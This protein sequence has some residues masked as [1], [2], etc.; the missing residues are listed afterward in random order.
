MVELQRKPFRE[1]LEAQYVL[2]AEE[3]RRGSL[4]GR[5]GDGPVE[6]RQAYRD[7][8]DGRF[9]E[10]LNFGTN[11]YLGL[12]THPE[13]RRKVCEAVQELGVGTGGSPAFSG[14]TRRHSGLERRLAALAG[15]EDAVLLPSGFMANLCWVT[16]LL[17]RQDVLVYDRY[18]HA[19]VVNAV[20][21]A[22]VNFFTFDPDDPEAFDALLE[23]VVRRRGENTQIFSTLEGVRSVDGS[24]ADVARWIETCRKHG[25]VT[26]LDDAHG[27]GTVGAKG[28]G[29]LEHLGLLGQVDFRMSTCSKGLGAQG[30]FLSG[31]DKA[32]FYLRSLSHPY[33]F[34][35]ALAHPTVAA[36][37][38]ALDVLQGDPQL[39]RSL[40]SNVTT[41]RDALRGLGLRVGDAPAGIVPVYL[42][43]GIARPFN[44]ALYQA[45]LFAHVMEYPMVPPGME[46]VRLTVMATH[47]R[48]HLD[49]AVEIIGRIA[50]EF[51]VLK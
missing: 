27:L 22:G 19:S 14:Y 48:E 40:R 26:V 15:H 29:T 8:F 51:E 16:G 25:V 50:R 33:V 7:L 47:T 17:R 49:R 32:I 34:T 10:V 21:M 31:S 36:I 23:Q 3:T 13:V 11:N 5:M 2:H 39:L 24:I 12:A 35:T 42:P 18:S 41:L 28:M 46:R 9:N 37:G 4:L 45:G 20:K 43:D 1:R 30:A 6:P 44:R 38:A